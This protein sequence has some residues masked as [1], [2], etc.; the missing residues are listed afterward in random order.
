MPIFPTINSINQKIELDILDKKGIALFIKREDQSH[1]LYGGNKVRKLKYH[2]LDALQ[3]GNTHFLTFG[4]AWSNHIFASAAFFNEINKPI[5]GV[6]RGEEPRDYSDTLRFAKQKG[7][8]LHFVS[9]S[10]YRRRYDADFLEDLRHKFD[11]PYIIPEGGSGKTGVLGC[12][13]I[14]DKNDEQFDYIT[15]GMGTGGTISGITLSLLPHQ[16][17]IGFS[18]LKGGDF[19]QNDVEKLMDFYSSKFPTEQLKQ[20]FVLNTDYHFGGF[21]KWT[22]E[23]L[24]FMQDFYNKTNIQLDHIYTGKMM[25]GLLDLIQKDYFIPGTKILAI[26][27]GGHQGLKGLERQIGKKIY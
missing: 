7:M 11:Q 23:L 21:A 13:E 12:T 3:N 4:G 22:P 17:S 8:Q 14:L 9:R 2:V 20:Q 25:F 18:A 15:S 5:V 27:T 10:D 24:H 26:H 6:I 16:K 1:P 19:L